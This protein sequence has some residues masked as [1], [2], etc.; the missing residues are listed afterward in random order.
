MHYGRTITIFWDDGTPDGIITAS[1]SNWNGEC[2]KIPRE[3][4]SGADYDEMNGPGVYFL[5]CTDTEDDQNAVYVGEA[6][7]LRTRLKQHIQDFKSGKEK[8]Y[9]QNAVMF[10]GSELN[11]TLIRYL[12]HN[13]TMRAWAA[14]R[15]AV[16]TKNTFAD[17]IV[18]R[19]EKA[20]MEEFMDNIQTLL[21]AL[22]YR[23]LEPLPKGKE[24]KATGDTRDADLFLKLGKA[25]GKGI[26]TEDGQFLLLAGSHVNDVQIKSCPPGAVKRREAAVADGSVSPDW[27]TTED[28]MF[29]S[30]SA[31]ASFLTGYA[32]SG[33]HSWKN[34]E[35]RSLF[36]M[37]KDGD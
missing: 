10:T 13:L 3:D 31:A 26:L 14:K 17:S 21:A 5:I 25:E 29:K 35:G 4:V 28:M 6:E 22:N 34:E 23:I 11:K 33:P 20:A 7:N 37:Q 1:L 16:L 36:E 32:V 9:W 2:I 24:E 12:E 15:Y 18:K 19:H 8:Y 30:T 27:I